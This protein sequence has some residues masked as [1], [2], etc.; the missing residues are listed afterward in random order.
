M[1]E[2]VKCQTKICNQRYLLAALK[3]LEIPFE[4]NQEGVTLASQ[5]GK[6]PAEVAIRRQNVQGNLYGDIGFRWDPKRQQYELV[7]VIEDTRRSQVVDLVNK[8]A[9]RHAYY[10]VLAQA[11]LR[12]YGLVKEETQGGVIKLRLRAA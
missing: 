4:H 8:V 11:R 9:Q 7:G 3:D 2:Y 12:G 6:M 5:W 1:S 10:Q